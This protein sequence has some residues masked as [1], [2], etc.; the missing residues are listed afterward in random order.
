MIEQP[1]FYD[2]PA[3]DYHADPC[4]VPSLS[5]T[6]AGILINATPK[7]AWTAH[8]RLNPDHEPWSNDAMD[9]GS[10]AHELVLGKGGGYVISPY[11]EFRTKEAKAW[12]DGVIESG[13]TPIKAPAFEAARGLTGSILRHVSVTHGAE[14][15]FV[16]EC[17]AAETVL[18]WRDVG[19]PL[20]RS[21]LDWL[22]GGT[23]FD[24]KTTSDLSDKALSNKIGDG[25]DLQAAFHLRGLEHIRPE[26]AGRTKWMWV[27]AEVK[28][29]F[30][31]RVIELDGATRTM[32]DKKAAYAIELWRR[33]LAQNEWPGY[34]R[35]IERIEYNHFAEA[36]WLAREEMDDIALHAR[37][38]HHPVIENSPKLLGPC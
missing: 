5:S 10:V 12:R 11:D 34:P 19:G 22:D 2:M 33:C 16:E 28:P 31:C 32:G 25:L 15:A 6:V 1:G 37:T 35:K 18:V 20:C 7:H 14:R 36:R 4:F 38:M 30:E 17:G 27:F 3:A 26:L 13:Q 23:I 21:M 24:L 8:P 9:L 29:P